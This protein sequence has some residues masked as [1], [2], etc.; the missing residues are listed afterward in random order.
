MDTNTFEFEYETVMDI[1]YLTV[2]LYRDGKKVSATHK[3]TSGNDHKDRLEAQQ[4]LIG[5]DNSWPIKR[6]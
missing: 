1:D 5:N 4:A 2:T 3:M 6:L